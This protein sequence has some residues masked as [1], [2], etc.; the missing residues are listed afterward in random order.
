MT[1]TTPPADRLTSP[2]RW[3]REICWVHGR[4]IVTGD[5]DEDVL[6]AIRQLRDWVAAGVTHIVDVRVEANDAELV[7]EYAP[8]VAYIWAGTHDAGGDQ[9][10]DWFGAVLDRLGDAVHDPDVVILVHCHMGVNRGPSMALR[11]MLEQG[12]DPV[13]A[14]VDLRDARPIANVEYAGAAVRHFHNAYDSPLEEMILDLR[15][16]R[17]WRED[18][19]LDLGW[20]ISRISEVTR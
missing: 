14:L 17:D 5:L 13:D 8:D 19:P 3:H 10:D 1:L 20:I 12:W 4:L 6:A 16:V 15:R 2:E 7:A 18:N 11:I 9:P